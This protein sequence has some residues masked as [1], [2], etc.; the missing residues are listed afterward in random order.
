MVIDASSG[1]HFN[2]GDIVL[3]GYATT[4]RILCRVDAVKAPIAYHK[5]SRQK[6]IR[7]KQFDIDT[8]QYF[9][10]NKTITEHGYWDKDDKRLSECD[11]FGSIRLVPIFGF[12]D[13]ARSKKQI[14]VRYDKLDVYLTHVNLVS[15]CVKYTELGNIIQDIARTNGM[16]L[17][18]EQ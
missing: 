4:G 8:Q 10:A 5:T 11:V 9:E 1:A 2:V 6:S 7:C 17:E 12:F 18:K 3:Y 15:L 14:T 16:I 13:N